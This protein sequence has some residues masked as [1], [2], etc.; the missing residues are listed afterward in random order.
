MY[1]NPAQ[2]SRR[3]VTILDTVGPTIFPVV[4]QIVESVDDDDDDDDARRTAKFFFLCFGAN[5]IVLSY[6]IRTQA[7]SNMLQHWFGF[8]YEIQTKTPFVRD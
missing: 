6:D 5:R 7:R 3:E 4:I 2:G 8:P 1:K